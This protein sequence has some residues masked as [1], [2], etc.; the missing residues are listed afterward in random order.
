MQSAALSLIK[1]DCNFVEQKQ[2]LTKVL[3]SAVTVNC[4]SV[5]RNSFVVLNISARNVASYLF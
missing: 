3:L 2:K 5:S 1:N 4:F